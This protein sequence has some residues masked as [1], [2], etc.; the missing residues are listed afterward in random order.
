MCMLMDI[1]MLI[2]DSL[3]LPFLQNIDMIKKNDEADDSKISDTTTT[4]NNNIHYHYH[5]Y[6][7]HNTNETNVRNERNLSPTH[8][9]QEQIVSRI[10]RMAIQRG[11]VVG[12]GVVSTMEIV[13]TQNK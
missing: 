8:N 9:I 7:K 2:E 3:S 5:Y 13:A 11:V 10:P 12:V 6:N 1:D 4:D